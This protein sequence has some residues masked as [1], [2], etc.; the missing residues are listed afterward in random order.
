MVRYT[1][2]CVQQLL[3]GKH[4]FVIYCKQTGWINALRDENKNQCMSMAPYDNTYCLMDWRFWDAGGV[5]INCIDSC[6]LCFSSVHSHA[7]AVWSVPL[8]GRLF[9]EGHPSKTAL[10]CSTKDH[11]AISLCSL[12]SKHSLCIGWNRWKASLLQ[13]FPFDHL[14]LWDNVT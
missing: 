13:S 1:D 14:K 5:F 7:R 3:H 6:V 11:T 10:R 4:T 8:H 9:A 2:G 12:S